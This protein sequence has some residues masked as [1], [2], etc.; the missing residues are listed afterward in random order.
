[1]SPSETTFASTVTSWRRW[2]NASSTSVT[3]TASSGIPVSSGFGAPTVGSALRARS[4][5]N[6]PTAPPANGGRPS[7]WA[8]RQRSSSSSTSRYGSGCSPHASLMTARGRKP[9]NDQRPT[10]CPCSADSSRNDGPS[11]RSFRYAETGVS[12]SAMKVCRSGTSECSFASSRTSSSDGVSARSTATAIQHLVRVAQPHAPLG[13]Q[14][15]EVVEH[16]GGLLG[17]PLVALLARGARDLLG[18]LP[19]LLPRELA[20]GEE[21]RG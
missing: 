19:H 9:R 16:V 5:P 15:G 8:I 14:H 10:C 20:V 11:P 18:L 3:I 2:S 21:T 4:Y 1:M 13:E 12:Q 6:M 17:H 7:S